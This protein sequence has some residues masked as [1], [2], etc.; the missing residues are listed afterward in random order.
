[1]RNRQRYSK[2]NT[3]ADQKLNTADT[4]ENAALEAARADGTDLLAA[5]NKAIDRFLSGDSETFNTQARQ[6]GGQ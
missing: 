5:A 2:E 1:M 4:A 3:H 6:R